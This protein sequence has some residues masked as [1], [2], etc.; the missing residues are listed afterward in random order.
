MSDKLSI[1]DE[2]AAID[3]GARDLWD[4]LTEDQKKQISF[5]LLNR[6]ASSI[7]TTDRDQQE[8]AVFKTNEY[9]NKHFFSLSKHQKLLWY[10]LCMTGNEKKQIYFHEY[11]PYK[12]QS[13]NNSKLI[14][15]L[16]SQY[17]NL[18][19]IEIEL[20]VKI[21]DKN[22]FKSLAHDLGFSDDEIKKLL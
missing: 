19:E 18:N 20:L 22:E 8:L 11:I 6:Y 10:L 9:Y 16:E 7:K 4:S 17:P 13:G 14:K 15:F 12:K 5:Y 21:N 1:K 3:M 2:T